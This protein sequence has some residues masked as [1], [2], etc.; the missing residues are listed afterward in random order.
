MLNF[1]AFSFFAL[2]LAS[3][4]LYRFLLNKRQYLWN[5]ILLVVLFLLSAGLSFYIF[6]STGTFFVAAIT[7][8]PMPIA[9]IAA[10]FLFS[11]RRKNRELY[12]TEKP[13]RRIYWLGMFLIPIFLIS[14]FFDLLI[15]RST[16][17][18][19]NQRAAQPIITAIEK[20]REE[21]GTPL[22]IEVLVPEYLSEVPTGKCAPL[23]GSSIEKPVFKIERCTSEEVS[24][25]TIPI[26]SGEWIQRYNIETEKWATLSFLDGAC[27]YLNR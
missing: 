5:L 6:F 10:L 7:C 27:S 26:T 17:F 9:L 23:P 8:V 15:F 2:A 21:I 18:N 13:I 20:Y 12:Q 11:W 19:L 25:L 24:I 14:P 22:S 4:P 1:L 3:G 16:C